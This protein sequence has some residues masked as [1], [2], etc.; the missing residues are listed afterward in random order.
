M[1]TDAPPRVAGTDDHPGLLDALK[2]QPK[3]VWVTAFAAVIAFMGI[4]LVDP[5]L[6][7]ITEE[8][9]ATPSQTT[10]LFGSYLGVQVF[11]MLLTG[12]MS[13][14]FGAKRTVVTGLIL[15]V[16]AAGVCAAAQTI[17]Q[18]VWLRALWGLGNAFFIATALTVIV[19]AAAGGQ[20]GAILLYEA[21]LGLGLSVGPLLGAILGSISWR[22]PFAGTA[23]LMAIG[24]VLCAVLLKKDGDRT[25]RTPVRLT[26]P[27]RALKDRNL[28]LASTGSAFYTA[29][30]FTIIAWAPFAL[31]KGAYYIGFVFFGW[32]V[33]VAIAGVFLAPR[34]AALVGERI[35][36]TGTV[37]LFAVDL[38]AVALGAINGIDGLIVAGVVISGLLSGILNTL[39][40]G[41]AMSSA[42]TERSI[43]SA[44]YN[45]CRWMGGAVAAILVGHIAEWFGA[46]AAPFWAAGICCLVSAAVL[47]FRA[48]PAEGGEAA[49]G[50][51]AAPTQ[52]ES[53]FEQLENGLAFDGPAQEI[54]ES[55]LGAGDEKVD[56]RA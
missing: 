44:G 31:G 14:R 5:I 25:N 19:G 50:G 12:L 27:I 20:K 55:G 8:L 6:N 52:Q 26:D 33:C 56:T 38:V 9:G 43:S 3:Q 23:I 2:G 4:G 29:A 24:A 7:T 21:A 48:A 1:S 13:Y 42:G 32:G 22:G 30:F 51:D 53:E 40:T 15:I 16:I 36:L 37:T 11:A 10:L 35:A 46:V 49:E 47:A 18:L 34:V 41:A 54:D 17:E 28:L 39:L 45:F